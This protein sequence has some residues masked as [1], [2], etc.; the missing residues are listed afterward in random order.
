ME[1]FTARGQYMDPRGISQELEWGKVEE[2]WRTSFVGGPTR[3]CK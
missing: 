3:F 2:F 1:G